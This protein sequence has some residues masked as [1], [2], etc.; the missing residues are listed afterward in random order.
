[1]AWD[2]EVADINLDEDDRQVWVPVTPKT[3]EGLIQEPEGAHKTPKMKQLII[4]QEDSWLQ[5]MAIYAVSDGPERAAQADAPVRQVVLSPQVPGQVII[6]D[7]GNSSNLTEL[8]EVEAR[9]ETL[10]GWLA[11]PKAVTVMKAAGVGW[12]GVVPKCAPVTTS[13]MPHE[14]SCDRCRRIGCTCFSRRKGRQELRAC[15]QCYKAKT[16]CKTSRQDSLHEDI[17]GR[18]WPGSSKLGICTSGKDEDGLAKQ[19]PSL[20]PYMCRH[21]WKRIK[22]DLWDSPEM[23]IIGV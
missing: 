20:P 17:V 6:L 7:M 14:T 12:K 13:I 23:G 2:G 18:Q 8:S 15:L 3:L 11:E 21:F 1:M 10:E 19:S 9:E 5:N 22:H 16:A 4:S